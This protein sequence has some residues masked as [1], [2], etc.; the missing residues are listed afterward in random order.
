MAETLVAV[1]VGTSG[2][3]AT[4]FTVGGERVLE[5]RQGYPTRSERPG[6]AEQ[7]P[8]AWRSAALTALAG[9]VRQLGSRRRVVAIGLTGQ[10]P[11][12][13]LVNDAGEPV[14]PGL[15]Y[16]DNRATAEAGTIRER[17]GDAAIHART[18]HLPA[19]FH[20]G[21]KLMWLKAHQPE[22]F[23]AARY[24]LQPRDLVA[25]ALTGEFATD[26][27][28]AAATLAF[29]LRRRT[30]AD[31]LIDAMGLSRDLFPPV[32]ASSA[33]VGELLGS[34]ARRVGIEPGIPV[35]LGGA[36]SQACALGA[37]VIGAG[38]VSE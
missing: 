21:P 20:V 36:D 28:H 24:A 3:R 37:G 11:S 14:S 12:V 38:P 1:D 16:R 5:V 34:V 27:T 6:W 25:H 32:R 2:A 13:C 19:A 9:L 33:P 17:F 18:G 26:G 4:A 31:D 7:D 22:A 8:R 15:I 23:G 10:C 35:I 30:W 29:D